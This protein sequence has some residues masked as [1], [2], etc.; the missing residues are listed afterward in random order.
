LQVFG[1]TAPLETSKFEFEFHR[2]VALVE[3]LYVNIFR[4]QFVNKHAEKEIRPI[5]SYIDFTLGQ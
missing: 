2:E 3:K 1:S 5:S 4:L